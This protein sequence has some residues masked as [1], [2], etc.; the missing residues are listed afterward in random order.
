MR[1]ILITLGVGFALF[2][3]FMIW[4]GASDLEAD[5]VNVGTILGRDTPEPR[6]RTVTI[7]AVALAVSVPLIL[8]AAG[9]Q[10]RDA[11]R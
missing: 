10:R 5:Y 7:G 4:I 2:G 3:L 6:V 9:R 1:A 8:A 11:S